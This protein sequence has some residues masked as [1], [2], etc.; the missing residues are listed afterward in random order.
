MLYRGDI[1]ETF[2][3]AVGEAQAMGMP[4]VV[5]DLGSMRERVIDGETGFVA[6][7]DQ[8]F[9]DA[10]VKLLTDD[11]L[12]SAQQAAALEKQRSW[13]WPEAAEAWERLLP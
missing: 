2:C 13:R 12:W 9:A 3:M 5:T 8:A 4:A 7:D 11:A 10:A 6:R 1:N